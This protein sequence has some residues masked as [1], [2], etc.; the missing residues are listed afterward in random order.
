MLTL[1]G[2][3]SFKEDAAEDQLSAQMLFKGFIGLM[4][5]VMLAKVLIHLCNEVETMGDIVQQEL[6]RKLY[7]IIEGLRP[8]LDRISLVDLVLLLRDPYGGQDLAPNEN[9]PQHQ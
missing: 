6:T 7:D 8:Q 4:L 9:Q 1:A 3:H 2:A 5:F